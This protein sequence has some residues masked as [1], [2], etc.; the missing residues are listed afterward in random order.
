MTYRI[1]ALAT[2]PKELDGL[3]ERLIVSHYENNYG[4]A[5]RRLN[6]IS[7]ELAQL[8]FA[9]AP[10]YQIN[11]LKREELLAANSMSLH[12]I[13]FDGLGV[14]PA[15]PQGS[16]AAAIERDF[17]SLE[18]WQREFS[19]MGKA[20][21]GGSGWVLLT[22]LAAQGRLINQWAG[23]HAHVL[24][25][26]QVVL[27]L[28]MYEHAYHLDFGA[29]AA[30]YVDTYMR[31]IAWSWAEQRFRHL[32]EGG[33]APLALHGKDALAPE[34]L[35][36]A[37]AQG[38]APLL[39]DVRRAAAFEAASDMIVGSHW[40]APEEVD[41]WADEMPKDRE[42]LVYCV[43]GH[44][45]S[46]ETAAALRQR[47]VQARALAGGVATWHALGGATQARRQ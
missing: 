28:D 33:A 1:A 37:I 17:G 42:V 26:G 40:R 23:D 27:A 30:A 3:S 8:D 29:R 34:R 39:V 4:G 20:L 31:N 19:A 13:Y 36:E 15:G 7:R 43:F 22:W 41:A 14:E 18:R 6:A 47:G 45:V 32:A 46:E 12:E 11:G 35:Q 25:G 9:S 38:R 2:T 10:V 5:V 44:N 16:L 24:A 21:G